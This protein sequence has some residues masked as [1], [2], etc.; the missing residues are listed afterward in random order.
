MKRYLSFLPLLIALSALSF[1]AG[2]AQRKSMTGVQIKQN[3][4]EADVV[5]IRAIY[6]RTNTLP[7]KREAFRFES[8]GCIEDGLITYFRNNN[9]IVKITEAGSIGDG[10]WT[11]EFY[12]DARKLVFCVD[13]LTGGP[14]SGAEVT[15][16]YRLYV[17]NNRPVR[18]MENKKVIP[19]DKKATETISTAYKLLKAYQTKNFKAALCD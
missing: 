15:T 14:A 16:E 8:P 9:N 6:T 4:S 7:L 1:Q 17:K 2:F 3:N 12:F 19:P 18:C 5:S 11:T 13:Q 10:S